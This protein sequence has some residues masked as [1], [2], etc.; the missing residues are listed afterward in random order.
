[1][2][3]TIQVEQAEFDAGGHKLFATHIPTATSGRWFV[4][5]DVFEMWGA[6]AF[7]DATGEVLRWR[8]SPDKTV[9]RIEIERKIR[10]T[11]DIPTPIKCPVCGSAADV[12]TMEE[13]NTAGFYRCHGCGIEFALTGMLRDQLSDD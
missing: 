13:D 7:D 1:M 10:R 6:V 3:K 9:M 2:K 8:G 5:H 11:F 4:V 12:D